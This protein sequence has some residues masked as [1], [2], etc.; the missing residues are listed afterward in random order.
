MS[1]PALFPS[2]LTVFCQIHSSD[3]TVTLPALFSMTVAQRTMLLPGSSS[4]SSTQPP[5]ATSAG[6][7]TPTQL[8]DITTRSPHRSDGQPDA[9]E[10]NVQSYR[11][12]LESSWKAQAESVEQRTTMVKPISFI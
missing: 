5:T 3:R 9:V 8:A 1:P 6:E 7:D 4:W 2:Q 10:H 11:H 12:S